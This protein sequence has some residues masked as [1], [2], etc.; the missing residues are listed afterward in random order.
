MAE[1]MYTYMMITLGIMILFNLAGLATT[2]GII[3]GRFGITNP[4]SL[5]TFQ[6]SGFYVEAVAAIALLVGALGIAIGTLTR[7]YSTT[8]IFAGIA[9][10]ILVL[11]V[12]DLISIVAYA[13]Q[14]GN[15]IG[16]LVFAIMTPLIFGY[17]LSVLDW[18]RVHD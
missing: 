4:E 10:A 13:N 8:A 17:I 12:G 6:E 9:S 3:L 18:I 16:Y 2:T 7:G 11:F 15:W 1:K 14:S 5:T